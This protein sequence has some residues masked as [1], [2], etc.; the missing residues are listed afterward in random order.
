MAKKV[1]LDELV[2]E[3]G[4]VD[5]R[6]QAKALIM[7]GKVRLGDRRLDKPG[8]KVEEDIQLYVESGPRFVSR[9]GEKL[10]GFIESFDLS[11]DGMSVMD[12]GAST[13]GFSDC[14]LQHGAKSIT[15]IDVGKGQLHAKIANDDRVTN[16]EKVNARLLEP[17]DLP[18]DEYDRIVM[19]L[20]F[21]S[22][23]SVLPAVWGFLKPDGILVALVKPQFEVGKEIADK[24]RG[25]IKDVSAREEAYDS[26]ERFALSELEGS[27]MIGKIESPIKGTDGNVEY[28]LGLQRQLDSP[29]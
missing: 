19:D 25:V 22:L 11:F 18:L 3:R 14:A 12:V 24:Y 13:G 8:L 21:I 7:T 23:K 28:L 20:S 1:R 27:K 4:L 2:F 29:S 17:G 6:S 5:S 16:L 10:L 15:C 26:V 9:G